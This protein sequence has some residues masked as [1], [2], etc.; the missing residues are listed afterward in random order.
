MRLAHLSLTMSEERSELKKSIFLSNI[1]RTAKT[2]TPH[3][4]HL[5]DSSL[6]TCVIIFIIIVL[7]TFLN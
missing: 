2:I 5:L 3:V 4:N 1:K 6:V 7:K